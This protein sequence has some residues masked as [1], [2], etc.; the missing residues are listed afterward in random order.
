MDRDLRR[1]ESLI[2][3][4]DNE[5]S[6]ISVIRIASQAPKLKRVRLVVVRIYMVEA[7][8]VIERDLSNLVEVLEETVDR[9]V[10]CP[11]P[12]PI[13]GWLT[14]II[15]ENFH[16]RISA[17]SDAERRFSGGGSEHSEIAA[18]TASVA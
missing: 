12:D 11:H 3:H 9:L 18:A 15:M 14:N 8:I 16:D 7:E 13:I 5:I 4:P 17:N 1:H 2:D 10:V 6:T